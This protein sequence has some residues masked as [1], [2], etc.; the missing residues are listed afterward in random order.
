MQDYINKDALIVEIQKTAALFIREFDD[1]Q[2]QDQNKRLSDV[3]RTPHEMIAYQLGWLKLIQKWDHDEALG[4]DVFMPAKGYKWNQLGALYQS[5][6]DT[7]QE[8]SLADLKTAFV[9]AVDEVIQWL[10]TFNEADLFEPDS[11]NWASSTPSKW[12]VW[13]WV[14][15]N[16]VAPFKSFRTQIRKWKKLNTSN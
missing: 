3:E 8:Q 15:I 2:E 5:F 11:R 4:Y 7:Y 9:S 10:T 16:T 1:V 13:K 14:H 12:P 6:Y